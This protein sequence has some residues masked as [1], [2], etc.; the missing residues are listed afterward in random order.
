MGKGKYRIALWFC[1]AMMLWINPYCV[2]ANQAKED[3]VSSLKSKLE[4]YEKENVPYDT[5]K[6]FIDNEILPLVEGGDSAV[7]K[8][9]VPYL[10]P[11]DNPEEAARLHNIAF[12]DMGEESYVETALWLYSFDKGLGAE[13]AA[14]CVKSGHTHPRLY[15]MLARA[16]D[17]KYLDNK[18]LGY[19]ACVKDAINGNVESLFTMAS[20]L[21]KE[22]ELEQGKELLHTL[23]EKS[24]E[25]DGFDALLDEC[26]YYTAP[27]ELSAEQPAWNLEASLAYRDSVVPYYQKFYHWKPLGEPE[28][29]VKAYKMLG[30][31]SIIEGDDVNAFKYLNK[32]AMWDL[33][34]AMEFFLKF[35]DLYPTETIELLKTAAERGAKNCALQ[36]GMEYFHGKHVKK[37]P[38]LSLKY[39]KMGKDLSDNSGSYEFVMSLALEANGRQKEADR[40][41]INSAQKGF[42]DA[43][44]VVRMRNLR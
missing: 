5:I 6:V 12:K 20:A 24:R 32:S 28:L 14:A 31:M 40:W 37:N 44:T 23:I 35:S 27:S 21:I 15:T 19:K 3:Y 1:S 33:D 8:I 41:M 2:G 7:A 34:V 43:Q 42:G 25:A 29:R 17:G 11:I 16:F 9:I 26:V 22:K 13:W 30:Y 38:A 39:A 36:L 18:E 10:Y 4:R